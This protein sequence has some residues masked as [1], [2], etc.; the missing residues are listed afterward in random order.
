MVPISAATAQDIASAIASSVLTGQQSS[1]GQHATNITQLTQ[2]QAASLQQQQQQQQALHQNQ[3][4]QQSHQNSQNSQQQ[5]VLQAQQQ[6]LQQQ[7]HQATISMPLSM[8]TNHSGAT[9]I[10]QLMAQHPTLNITGLT[11]DRLA[12]VT[13]AIQQTQEM[14]NQLSQGQITT[15]TVQHPETGV[16]QLV[17]VPSSSLGN[18]VIQQQHNQIS[19]ISSAIPISAVVS[20]S[21]N[22]VIGSQQQGQAN[23]GQQQRLNTVS[24]W[25][26]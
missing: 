17:V 25:S 18:A 12:A 4:Q 26:S 15:T 1:S 21:G 16:T 10:N 22:N 14:Q 19:T 2:H 9:T 20:A 24:V 11:S 3:L 5:Q 13:A 6:V 7:H 23:A 8:L